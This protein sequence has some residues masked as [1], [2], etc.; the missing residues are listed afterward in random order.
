VDRGARSQ[1]EVAVAALTHLSAAAARRAGHPEAA[2]DHAAEGLARLDD[3]RPGTSAPHLAAALAAEWI[4]ALVEAGRAEEACAA[5][6]STAKHLVSLARPTRQIALLRLT[7]A[8]A[9]AESSS[10]GAFEA[11]EQAASD[12]SACDAPDLEGLCLSAL[13]ALREQAGRIDA[14]LESMRRGVAAQRRDRAR[15]ERFRAA[16]RALPLMPSGTPAL[17][18]AAGRP[19]SPVPSQ[20]V[21]ARPLRFG[22]IRADEPH[23]LA[24]NPWTTGR[25]TTG[26]TRSD[27]DVGRAAAIGN[28]DGEGRR[29]LALGGE[30]GFGSA[31]A[32]PHSAGGADRGT[33]SCGEPGL[34][35]A[36]DFPHSA[37]GLGH[38]TVLGV[39]PGSARAADLPRS[40]GGVGRRA[41]AGVETGPGSAGDLPHTD[42]GG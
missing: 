4:T 31:A 27:G 20:T 2:A 16:L 42:G 6:T 12:A 35:S 3:L 10:P 30:P 32:F 14:A 11:L 9:L 24:A 41:A 38:G 33:A 19:N 39:E 18:N 5:C 22:D 17:M 28:A 1:A 26:A 23:P 36:T 7:V 37:G 21:R 8:R 40:D 34:G 13:G 25:W 29:G 15:S